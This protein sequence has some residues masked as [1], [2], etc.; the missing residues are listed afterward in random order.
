MYV[1]HCHRFHGKSGREYQYDLHPLES[2][3]STMGQ[4][5]TYI[6]AAGE[7]AEPHFLVCK[8]TSDLRQA[9]IA[10]NLAKLQEV[11]DRLMLYVHV[12]PKN[13]KDAR[14]AEVTDITRYYREWQ[15]V[16]QH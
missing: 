7:G 15:F 16:V 1:R 12:D 5:A 2:A 8:E 14:S 10:E 6:L 9:L 11:Q 4:A 3:Q 13:E